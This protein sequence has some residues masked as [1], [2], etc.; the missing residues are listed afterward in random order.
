MLPKCYLALFELL[1]SMF[2]H[3]VSRQFEMGMKSTNCFNRLTSFCISNG[4]VHHE[5]YSMARIT[6]RLTCP[7]LHLS[8]HIRR[9]KVHDPQF[10]KPLLQDHIPLFLLWYPTCLFDRMNAPES[11]KARC[12][13]L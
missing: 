13:K 4:I 1:T 9:H 6:R 11:L 5:L 10:A 2:P 12:L 8:S 7:E 3:I